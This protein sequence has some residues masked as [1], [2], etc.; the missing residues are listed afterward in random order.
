VSVR[1]TL[2][3]FPVA[4]LLIAGERDFDRAKE[5]FNATEFEK[6]L[7]ILQA[8]PEKNAAVFELM[9]RNFFLL[10]DYKRASE[11]L[12]KAA[13]ADPAS[14]EIALWAGRA[15]GR[16]A[17]NSN[18]LL[19]PGYA[20]RARQYFEKSVQL[21]AKNLEALCDLFEY[22]LEAPGFLGGGMDK[23][24]AIAARIAQVDVS[25][26]HWSQAKLAEKRKEYANAEKQL[27]QAAEISPQ[28]VGWLLELA[29]FFAQRGRYEETE[30]YLAQAERMAPKNPHVIYTKA[31]IYVKHKRNLQVAKDLL[32]QYMSMALSPDDPPRSEAAK[33]LRSV[34]GS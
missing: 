34:Q 10:G 5:L 8:I 7:K 26:G 15:F 27:R 14:S 25:E 4:A 17:E 24:E 29:R 11:A 16:R 32:I 23:A 18:F 33:L 1:L 13:Q 20:S 21:N 6:S 28:R 31:E 19:A 3:L 12:E 22:Y 30:Q 9:G 2:L